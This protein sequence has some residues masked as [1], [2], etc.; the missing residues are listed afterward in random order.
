MQRCRKVYKMRISTEYPLEKAF[1]IVTNEGLD[2]SPR[3]TCN[4]LSSITSSY[5]ELIRFLTDLGPKTTLLPV[6]PAIDV[7]Y[8]RC[9][10]CELNLI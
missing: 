1:Q 9:K 8:L 2:P 10:R 7:V 6:K 3:Q 5:M 4:E